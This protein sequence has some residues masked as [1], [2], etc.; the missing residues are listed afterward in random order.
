MI[1][2]MLELASE[3]LWQDYLKAK[4]SSAVPYKR[5]FFSGLP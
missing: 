4:G 1:G 5:G 3:L 2:D